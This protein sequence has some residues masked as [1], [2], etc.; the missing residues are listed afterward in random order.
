MSTT[1][2]LS[3]PAA[4]QNE[5]NSKWVLSTVQ[6]CNHSAPIK[7]IYFAKPHQFRTPLNNYYY[8]IRT[9][10]QDQTTPDVA[11]DLTIASLHAWKFTRGG[12]LPPEWTCFSNVPRG[13]ALK[14][15]SFKLGIKMFQSTSASGC[16]IWGHMPGKPRRAP[17]LLQLN[18]SNY[19]LITHCTNLEYCQWFRKK[20]HCN[21]KWKKGWVFGILWGIEPFSHGNHH[22][23]A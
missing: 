9:N 13:W 20:Y 17:H 4:I 8:L 23:R 14:F 18:S 22:V 12:Q 1:L 2:G 5:T 11:P 7:N 21:K 10:P 15:G 19:Y 16:L 3:G 6:R